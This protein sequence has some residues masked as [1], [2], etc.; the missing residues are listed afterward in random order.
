M[1]SMLIGVLSGA[2]MLLMVSSCATVPTEPPAPGEVRLLGVKFAEFGAIRQ[3]L[4]YVVEIKFES[5]GQ[6]DVTRACLYWDDHGPSCYNIMDMSH[7]TKTIRVGVQVPAP[8]RYVLKSY[9]QS[10]KDGRTL[11]S[12]VV[13]TSVEIVN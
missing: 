8:G 7:G 4:Q 13:Q 1:K 11:K 3:G 2:V 6:V 5:D 10:I 9:V 12:N